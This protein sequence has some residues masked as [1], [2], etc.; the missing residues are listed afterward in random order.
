MY[1]LYRSSAAF[2]ECFIVVVI[3]LLCTTTTQKNFLHYPLN[4]RPFPNFLSF[5]KHEYTHWIFWSVSLVSIF[6]LH[7]YVT[8]FVLQD[9]SDRINFYFWRICFLLASN[10]ILLY[11]FFPMKISSLYWNGTAYT[12][13]EK[14]WWK[15]ADEYQIS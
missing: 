14:L 15:V 1:T 5:D 2:Y 7:V 3:T 11:K 8:S 6:M 4:C 10:T 12:C 9:L 13:K